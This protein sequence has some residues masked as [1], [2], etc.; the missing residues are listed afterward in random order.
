MTPRKMTG[1]PSFNLESAPYSSCSKRTQYS[2]TRYYSAVDLIQ[3]LDNACDTLASSN[4]CS[5][6]AVLLF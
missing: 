6:D 5:N 1:N 4:A 3:V 2:E